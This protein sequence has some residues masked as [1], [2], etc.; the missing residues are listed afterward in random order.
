MQSCT[1]SQRRFVMC[2]PLLPADSTETDVDFSIR[3]TK[4]AGVTTIPVRILGY[5]AML[6]MQTLCLVLGCGNPE[7]IL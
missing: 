4:E 1:D 2:R 5:F 7:N 6:F 3:L